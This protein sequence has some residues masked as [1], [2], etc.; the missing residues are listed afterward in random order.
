MNGLSHS[1]FLLLILGNYQN[2]TFIMLTKY[3][4]DRKAVDQFLKSIHPINKKNKNGLCNLSDTKYS[5]SPAKTVIDMLELS[6]FRIS[7]PRISTT[8]IKIGKEI[9]FN[10]SRITT[11]IHSPNSQKPDYM[12]LT[13]SPL[14]LNK[15]F[16][17]PVPFRKKHKK[18]VTKVPFVK[19]ID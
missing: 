15:R 17:T 6:F 12:K 18:I 14:N 7:S 11:R 2:S 4:F 8:R 9:C 13:G 5:E 19:W 16:T 10:K 3:N 1:L